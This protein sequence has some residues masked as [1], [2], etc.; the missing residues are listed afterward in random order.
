MPAPKLRSAPNIKGKISTT[1]K[2]WLPILQSNI[3]DIEETISSYSLENPCISIQSRIQSD[4]SSSIKLKST[5]PKNPQKSAISD[6]IEARTIEEQSLYQMLEAQITPPLFPTQKSQKIALDIIDNIND[7]GYFDGDVRARS[8]LLG[9]DQKEY[10]RIRARF[11][12]LEPRG[13]GSKNVD[14]ALNFHLDFISQNENISDQLY[15]LCAKILR[16]LSSHG[17][18]KNDPLYAD[19][20]KL[21]K[22]FQTP[23]ALAFQAND[24][25]VIPDLYIWESNG[26]IEVLIN[27]DFYPDIAISAPKGDESY[28]KT[29]LKEARD[30]VDALSM[31][32]Q[33]LK[34]IGL[35]IVEYQYDF[36]TGGEIAPMRLKDLADEFGHS[37]STISRAISDKY[38]EC[39]RGIFPLKAFF[40]TALNDGLSNAA[41]KDFILNLVKNE[42]K[43]A[44]LSDLA[45]LQNIKTNFNL[46]LVRRTITKY[47]KAL[48]I[49]SSND[50]KKT[51]ALG[52]HT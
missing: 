37:P 38:L 44:P 10:E 11:A 34:K 16:D 33:T 23:P 48:N 28:L 51:Y 12:Y 42:D 32:K 6:I 27:D 4:L 7:F 13:I 43:E 22:S 35:M 14:E 9:I 52:M 20:M 50:R 2:S 49:P 24:S 8:D 45:I 21:I 3:L 41:I 26:E 18:F 5:P 31:R 46:K 30:L 39:N 36:F 29:K 1:L 25:E 40:A 47:R 17:N 15:D 19:A